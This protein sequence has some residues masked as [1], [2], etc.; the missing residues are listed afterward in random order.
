MPIATNSLL[1]SLRVGY[2]KVFEDAKAAAPSQWAKLATLVASTAASTTYGWLGQFPKLREWTGDRVFKSIK[3]HGYAVTNKLYEATVDIPRTAF[4]DDELGVYS[5]LFSEM[6]YAAAT[7]PD[8][9]VFGLLAAGRTEDC[10][11]GKK[12]FAADHPVYPNVDGTGSVVNTSN[13]LRPAA[14]ES[15]VTDKTA[16][17]LLDVSR[18]LKP[19]IFQER[20]TPELQV[21]T[22]PD[23][24]TVFMKDKIPYGIRYRCNG[25]YGFWQQAVCC[26]D[27]L[28]AANFQ[29]ALETMQGFKADGGRPL[30]L[31]FGG[32]AGT[33]L[34]VPPTLQADARKILVAE[35]DDMGASNIWF[36]AATIVVSP[37]LA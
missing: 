6:G 8:E 16:W 5:P 14:V 25:G 7:H 9:I 32:K 28:T 12:F 21:I 34:V 4:E 37:W 33:L 20:T 31:G 17:Y 23:N 19:F 18:P 29:L 35:R 11:D 27:D 24:D 30:G 36:D 10:Y 13:L 15:V 2:S 26:T 22:N 1:N 3:E